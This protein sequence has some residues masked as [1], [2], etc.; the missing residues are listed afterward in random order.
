MALQ[1]PHQRLSA[2]V[3]TMADRRFS[4]CL[5]QVFTSQ[6]KAAT[7]K[8]S[9]F[10]LVA[11]LALACECW[12]SA[13]RLDRSSKHSVRQKSLINAQ[14]QL[15]QLD[16]AS[17]HGTHCRRLL[18][19]E[20]RLHQ[21]LHACSAIDAAGPLYLASN[22]LFSMYCWVHS[23]PLAQA[24]VSPAAAVVNFRCGICPASKEERHCLRS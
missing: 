24:P 8:A 18:S 6:H 20:R 14:L 15:R 10:F 5:L 9:V 1:L 2:P 17:R 23:V 11:L 4:C 19:I 22:C 16:S 3:G 13:T 7:M 21:R 12:I